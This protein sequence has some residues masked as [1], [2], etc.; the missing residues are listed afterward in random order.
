MAITAE[1][2]GSKYNISKETVDKFA[3]KSQQNWKK[4]Q[5]EGAFKAEIIS[6]KIKVKGKEIDF[7]VDEHPRYVKL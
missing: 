5:D 4:G 2:L 3:L 6:V 7:S 1:N